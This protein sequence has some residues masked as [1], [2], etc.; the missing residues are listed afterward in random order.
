VA[1]PK[2]A[3]SSEQVYKLAQ[4]GATHCE[5]AGFFDCER[6]TISK[7][8]SQEIAK[9][10]NEQRIKLRRL[11]MQ[12]AERGNITMLIWLGK[13]LLDQSENSNDQKDVPTTFIVDL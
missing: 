1:R 12:A 6:S 10:H 7:R 8:F 11:Q 5:I 9:G 2:K 3:I 13:T 4:L